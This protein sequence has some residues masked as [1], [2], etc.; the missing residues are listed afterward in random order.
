LPGTNN[1]TVFVRPY[2]LICWVYWMYREQLK[3][4]EK[5]HARSEEQKLFREKIESL[6]LW[7]HKL[8]N[9]RGTPGFDSKIPQAKD[10]ETSLRFEDWKR[11]ATNTSLA[12]AVLP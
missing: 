7:G 9:L 1:A 10:G 2:S 12:A 5:G 6:H 3:K 11:S 4:K 8:N